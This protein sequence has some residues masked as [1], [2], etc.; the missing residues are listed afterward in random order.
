MKFPPY[1]LLYVVKTFFFAFAN[2]DKIVEN[3]TCERCKQAVEDPIHALWLCPELDEAWSD[4]GLWG[5]GYAV[6]FITVK[7]L[8]LW[9]VDEGKSLEL[10]AFTTWSVWNQRNKARLN[11]QASPLHQVAS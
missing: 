4:Q 8:L 2:S 6:G 7:E 9:M 5:F 11:L 10:F 3:P 1:L